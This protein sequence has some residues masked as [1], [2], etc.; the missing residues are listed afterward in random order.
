MRCMWKRILTWMVLGMLL[1]GS[2][3]SLTGCEKDSSLE[4]AAEEVGDTVEDTAEEVGD[5]AEDAADAV[6]DEM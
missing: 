3:A 1:A 6:E 2:A 5:A 4:N